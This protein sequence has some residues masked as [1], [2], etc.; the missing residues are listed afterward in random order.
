MEACYHPQHRF[1]PVPRFTGPKTTLA[2]V[3]AGL[4][5]GISLCEGQC[6][7]NIRRIK[8][9]KTWTCSIGNHT[10]KV[11]FI[12]QF[13]VGSLSI[14]AT[15]KKGILRWQVFS[16]RGIGI[17]ENYGNPGRLTGNLEND[18]L[19]DVV[20]FQ[21]GWFLGSM[22]IHFPG[23]KHHQTDQIDSVI[24]IHHLIRVYRLDFHHPF[25]DVPSGFPKQT[26]GGDVFGHL[27]CG[28]GGK[29]LVH[30]FDQHNS[31]MANFSFQ[32]W[33]KQFSKAESLWGPWIL[34]AKQPK[35]TPNLIWNPGFWTPNNRSQTCPVERPLPPPKK[36]QAGKT[37][38]SKHVSAMQA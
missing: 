21:S 16:G 2:A 10:P 23:S 30:D 17:G 18:G 4:F 31:Y 11:C 12:G 19:E 14:C 37:K 29:N 25:W 35:T 32:S 22:L 26:A 1:P 36:K 15:E 27:W 8:T 20:P 3:V 34:K 13:Q 33:I 28:F 9:P 7:R 38:Y 6:Q 24:Q 5:G